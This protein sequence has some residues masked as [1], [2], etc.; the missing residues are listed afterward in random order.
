MTTILDA[1]KTYIKTYGSLDSNAAVLV[2][3]LGQSP[4][5]YAIVPVP[6]TKILE[7]YIDGGSRREFPFSFQSMESTAN[8]LERIANNG[9]FEAFADWLESQ[10]NA[11]VLPTL[12]ANQHPTIIEA[13]G[14]GY[15]FQQGE[16]DTGI[17]S[18]QCRLE[19]EQD[20]P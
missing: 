9:F 10:T 18:I 15:L 3:Y 12:N 5:Q 17:Y 13:T 14:W 7:K 11:N 20:R 8:E 4:T 1:V 19:Y 6:G 2:D 16:S